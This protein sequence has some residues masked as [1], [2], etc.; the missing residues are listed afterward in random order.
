ML[1]HLVNSATHCK[2][3]FLTLYCRSRTYRVY[4]GKHSLDT[5][6]EDGSIAITPGKIVVH[7][8]WDSYNIRWDI[9]LHR[10]LYRGLLRLSL[11]VLTLVSVIFPNVPPSSGLQQ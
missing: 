4:L 7:E 8:A 6:N 5:D 11:L 1:E 2:C 3:Y 9:I 10:T